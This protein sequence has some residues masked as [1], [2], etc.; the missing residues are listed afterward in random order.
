MA[1]DIEQST[2]GQDACRVPRVSDGK[3]IHDLIR[4]C[5]PLDV[6]S[7]YCYLLL[8][9]HFADT[10]VLA[11]DAGDVV[12]FVS[13]YR[14]PRAPDTIFVW[15]VAV[16]PR[17]RGAGLG[18]RMLLELL[19]RSS[20]ASVRVLETTISP[21]NEASWALFGSLARKLGSPMTRGTLFQEE[22]FGDERHDAE[23]LLR[24]GPIEPEKRD[25]LCKSLTA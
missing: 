20:C 17:A 22:D 19:N 16:G 24:I 23:I 13:A 9:K 11:E 6:N 25:Q 10:C 7:S 18:A 3:G 5:P 2:T 12:G 15:Q 21:E 8:C 1:S 4:S 14:K